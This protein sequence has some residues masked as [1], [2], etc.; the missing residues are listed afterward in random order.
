MA[1]RTGATR[2]VVKIDEEKCDGC[3]LC[4]PACAEGALEII[5]GKARLVS[6]IY[7]DGLSACLYECPQGPSALRRGRRGRV[8]RRGSGALPGS[9]GMGVRVE[10]CPVVAPRRPLASLADMAR[11]E[12]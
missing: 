2:K 7:C 1:A 12:G 11:R 9:S 6:E 3:G 5:D 10:R 8:Q 4:I